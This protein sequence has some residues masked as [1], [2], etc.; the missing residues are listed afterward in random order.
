MT[1]YEVNGQ[2]SAIA[3]GTVRGILINMDEDMAWK[4]GSK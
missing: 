4:D 3:V 1:G 2:W